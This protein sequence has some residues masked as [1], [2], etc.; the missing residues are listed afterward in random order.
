M[1][2]IFRC[3]AISFIAVALL[4]APAVRAQDY[5]VKPIRL[6]VGPGPDVL[7]RLFG[8]QFTDAWG[9]QVIIDQRSGAG[10]IISAQLAAK[11]IPDGY[12]LLMI[13][14]SYTINSVL[15]PSA[16]DVVKDFSTVAL[17]ATSPFIL[18]VNPSVQARSVKELVA[19]AKAAP[20]K[21]NYASS[22]S[23]TGPHLAFEM[24][25]S[26][27]GINMVHVPYKAAAPAMVDLIAGEVQAN[28]QIA[29]AALPQVKSGKIRA[30][31]V[32]SLQRSRLAPDLPTL[33]E[34]GYDG[35]EAIGWNGLVAPAGTP[36]A[37]I[38]KL[39]RE[40]MAALKQ[41]PILQ[42][43]ADVGWEPAP[44]NSPAWFADYIKRDVAKWSR[45]VKETGAKAD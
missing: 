8:Q 15:Q 25:K 14:S 9:Q 43:I 3:A 41:P 5:P 36:Q 24:F 34:S 39:H 23:G 13:T 11:A 21:L 1:T 32:T 27:A 20:G 31:A 26:A 12:T 28:F 2:P 35:F 22:G 42:R 37:V 29:P 18:L 4:P 45:V 33:V 38:A 6:I 30:L 10:G 17:C 16:F 7:S 44:E 40:L 19:L